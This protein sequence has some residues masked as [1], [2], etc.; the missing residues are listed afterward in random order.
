MNLGCINVGKDY[1]NKSLEIRKAN[2]LT[3]YPSYA[4]PQ[5]KGAS[6]MEYIIA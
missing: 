2:R 1:N 5:V 6:N 3:Y 4:K